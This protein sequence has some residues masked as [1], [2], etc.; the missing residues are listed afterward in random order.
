MFIETAAVLA[1]ALVAW[2]YHVT[3]GED[4]VRSFLITAAITGTLGLVLFLFGRNRKMQFDADDTYVIV[5]IS[6]V[7]FSVFGMLPFLLGGAVD[8]VT[9]AFFETMSGF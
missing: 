8:N 7:M 4:D 5:T 3:L 6:W 2:Y 9:D 1:T